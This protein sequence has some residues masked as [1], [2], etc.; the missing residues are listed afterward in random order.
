MIKGLIKKIKF[1]RTS[2]RLG[3]D[4]PFTHW[5]LFFDKLAQRL[6]QKK[7]FYLGQN[8]QVRAGS[9]VINCSKIS[10]G[11]NVV[12]R[13]TSM[14][15][16]DSRGEGANIIIEDNVMLGSGVQ[17]Y[18]SNHRYENPNIEIIH[19]GHTELKPVK[20]KRGA[21]IGANS[22]ILSGVTVGENSVVGAGSV[23]TKSIPEK[24]VAAGNPAK[25]IKYIE[26]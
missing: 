21:W 23:V 19:Q 25:I 5:Q 22:I 13:P 15:F 8:T 1:D 7:F 4:C 10:L 24:C 18:T 14:L 11:N 26:G 3:P 20:I 16:A 6:C 17:I 12:I 2:D 9:Y